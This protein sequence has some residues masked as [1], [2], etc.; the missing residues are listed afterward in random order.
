MERCSSLMPVMFGFMGAVLILKLDLTTSGLDWAEQGIGLRYDME[1][2]LLR[3]DGAMRL[4]DPTQ[5][6]VLAGLGPT[7]LREHYISA[8]DCILIHSYTRIF[9]DSLNLW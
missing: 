7:R 4:H 1:F 2:F 5:Q 6:R 3:I 8:L 9:H